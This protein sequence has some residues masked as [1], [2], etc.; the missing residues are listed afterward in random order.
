MNPLN[1]DT[2]VWLITGCSTG[3]G[4]ALAARVLD[5]GHRLIATARQPE[6]LAELVA[7]DPSRCR[8]LALD[9]A[10][11]TQVAPVVAQA[12]AFFGR[13][14]V[15]VNNAGYGMIGAVEEYDEAQI[16]RNFETNFF[17]ALRVIR[18][19]LPIL[20]AQ[21]RGHFVNMSAA[22]VIANYAGFSIYGATKWALE[23]LSESLAA[24]VRPLGLK[25]TIVQPGPFRTDFI[26]RSLE[27]ASTAIPDYEATSG[28]FRR[29]LETMSGRQPGDPDKAADVIIAA[30]ES[31]N[32]P[33]RL[34]LGKYA[35]DKTRRK[36][37]SAARELEAGSA[38]GLATDFSGDGQ[39][40]AAR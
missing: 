18:A 27:R 5:R 12:A 29:F 3:L 7:V 6:T 9:V 33:L 13:L 15:V 14:D 21:R 20:R 1:N 34:V 40:E 25:V 8:A 24:E 10:D 39:A 26:S 11:A 30:V 37:V 31:E 36:L 35:I 2:H 32:P 16:A 23:G 22:A 38:A 28:K 4:R 19:A 17:G